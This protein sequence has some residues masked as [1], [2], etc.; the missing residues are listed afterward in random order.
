MFRIR[1]I[2]D[3]VRA[4]DKEAIRQVQELVRNRFPYARAA[5]ADDLPERL[6]TQLG[7][8]FRTMLYV[9][10]RSR[11]RVVGL[12]I[13]LHD[14][15]L[16]FCYL[17]YIASARGLNGR[18]IG[19]ALYDH[20]REEALALN[21]RALFFECLPD[22]PLQCTNPE[23]Y[24]HNVARMRFYELFGA[25]PIVGTAYQT[26]VRPGDECM[27]FLMFDGLGLEEPLS[28]EF[29]RAAVRSILEGKYAYLCP[30]E[31]R[32][33][34]IESFR[35]DPIAVR[36]PKYA[37]RPA[38]QIRLTAKL[39][40]PYP[41]IVNERHNIHHIRERGYVESPVRIKSI[42]A[43]IEPTGLFDRI[44]PKDYGEEHITAVHAPDFVDH[45]RKICSQV[46]P[47][48]SVYPYVFPI[49]NATR[50]PKEISVLAGY[51]CIDTFTPLN[52]NAFPAAKRAVDCTLTAADLVL[53]GRRMAYAL[54]RPPGHHAERCVFG[55]FCYFNNAAIAAHYLSA[56]GRV[57]IVDVDYHHGNGQQDIFY[58]RDDV[59]TISLHGD[60]S[61]AYPYF[62][63]FED[64]RG[65]GPGEGFNL[66]IPLAEV[67]DGATYRI[68]LANALV[69]LRDF[70][71]AFLIVAL[72]LD[73]AK[74]DPT[75]TWLL[76]AGDFAANGRMFGELGLPTLVVQE[77]G[78][79][80]RT[81]GVNARRFFEGFLAG[82]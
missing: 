37:K 43:E 69:A 19:G 63:G 51:Y 56:H 41:L 8:R 42:L 53:G 26:P 40:Q 32:E 44:E 14:P 45:L 3:D 35:D 25:R 24:K 36:P 55:G 13:L 66:N 17:D 39:R 12:A 82:S 30:P 70:K 67:Q 64:E 74:G 50:P 47:G 27:P 20:V 6:R 48:K 57:A 10:D 5:D 65:V 18:G 23:V 4:V 80:T 1:R 34:V 21:A 68:S 29:A 61:F 59:L 78:Y 76:T 15:E 71:P 7:E 60:P 58:H 79:R 77:G 54:V 81:L 46:P 49:R 72:G 22:D 2:Y 75:G 16:R 52:H 73:P 38:P 31:Y 9:A 62:T 11:G 33:K 28:P